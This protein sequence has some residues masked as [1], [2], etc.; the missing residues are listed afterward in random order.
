MTDSNSV[1]VV[2]VGSLGAY[3]FCPRAGLISCLQ[4][5]PDDE[6]DLPERRYLGFQ[7]SLELDVLYRN[8]ATLRSRF[9]AGLIL[10]AFCWAVAAIGYLTGRLYLLMPGLAASILPILL[11]A[12][13]V[14]E[15]LSLWLSLY[16]Y[17]KAKPHRLE[18]E[19]RALAPVF[20]WDLLKAGY[21]SVSPGNNF[22]SPDIELA[23]KPFRYLRWRSE[24][25][26]VIGSRSKEVKV[27]TSHRVRLAAY[28]LL[29]ESAGVGRCEWGIVISRKTLHG[30]AI[31]I[32]DSDRK[33]A[34]MT[35]NALQEA[36]QQFEALGVAPAPGH[37]HACA[38]C[39][40]GRPRRYRS[41]ATATKIE[42]RVLDPF[43]VDNCHCECGDVFQWQ[44]PHK[45]TKAF[46]T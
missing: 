26:P 23:G 18:L 22:H 13:S 42:Q 4:K 1:G 32:T 16:R 45:F 19:E 31:R 8:I 24:V 15:I 29:L 33:R 28:Q 5:K 39:S 44:P 46:G 34:N 36:A 20:W 3:E 9:R 35:K 37:A 25:I 21:E 43:I 27:R 41:A 40:K 38:G 10:C 11:Q 7:P 6:D 17:N 2:N 30:F 14:V 12:F